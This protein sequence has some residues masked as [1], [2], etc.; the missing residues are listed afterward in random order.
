MTSDGIYVRGFITGGVLGQTIAYA[1][2]GNF[3][4]AVAFFCL[5]IFFVWCDTK[6]GVL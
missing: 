3:A 5:W 1:M 6:D 2:T 4:G